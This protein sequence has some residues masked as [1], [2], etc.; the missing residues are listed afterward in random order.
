MLCV[1]I[2]GGRPGRR[3]PGRGRLTRPGGGGLG[4][5]LAE[6]LGAVVHQGGDLGEVG[7]AVG[8]GQVGYPFGPGALRLG[9]QRVDALPDPGVEDGGDVPGSAQVPGGDG[10]ADD[11]GGVQAG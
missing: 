4:G 10:R 8:Y 3:A 6:A 5:V 7:V 2:G 1:P 9:E 11:L